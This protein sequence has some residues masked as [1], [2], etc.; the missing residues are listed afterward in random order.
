LSHDPRPL[1]LLVSFFFQIGSHAFTWGWPQTV[2]LI[3]ISASQEAEITGAFYDFEAIEKL[4]INIH[5]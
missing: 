3:P 2:I 5:S 4:L 1:C